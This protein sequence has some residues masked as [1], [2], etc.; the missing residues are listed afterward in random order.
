[1]VALCLVLIPHSLS[2]SVLNGKTFSLILLFF[3][4]FD[5][6]PIRSLNLIASVTFNF[7]LLQ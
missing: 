7:L 1:M 6:L 4:D 5:S 2:P 3:R